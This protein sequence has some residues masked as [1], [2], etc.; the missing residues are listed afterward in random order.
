MCCFGVF[1]KNFQKKQ[2]RFLIRLLPKLNRLELC[3]VCGSIQR[4]R[5]IRAVALIVVTKLF[6]FT[7][8][9]QSFGHFCLLF[10]C[11]WLWRELVELKIKVQLFI[12]LI[13]KSV[14]FLKFWSYKIRQNGIIGYKVLKL[15]NACFERLTLLH[16]VL[17]K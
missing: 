14:L 16:N 17:L 15:T 1:P 8:R 12:I 7:H 4:R 3:I 2:T 9:S 5:Q 6:F 13:K 11:W 10:Y